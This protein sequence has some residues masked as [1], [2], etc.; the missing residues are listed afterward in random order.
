MSLRSQLIRLAHTNPILRPHLLPLLKVAAKDTADFVMWALKT[1]HTV[2]TDRVLQ[3]LERN[4]VNLVESEGNKRGMPLTLGELVVIQANNAPSDLRDILEPYHLK[5]GNIVEVDGKD[6]VIQIQ[7]GPLVRVPGGV[8][9]GKASGVYRT[10]QM[11]EQGSMKHLE[12]V[13]LPANEKKPAQIAVELLQKY[14][15]N[16]LA[17]G[18]ERSEN[19]FSGFV[20]SYKYSKDQNPYFTLWSQQRNGHPRSFSPN[21]GSVYYIG[22]VGK[23]PAGWQQELS[24]ML[25]EEGL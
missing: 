22:I 20:P 18:E 11:E 24:Q 10:S 2:S 25:Q 3:F 13:Y 8:D 23:R 14:V 5:K 19:Y 12:I 16:G 6:I 15:S 7:A 4:N 9:A 1:Q 17:A 21:K